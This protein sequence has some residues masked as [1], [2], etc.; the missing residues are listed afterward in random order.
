M[1]WPVAPAREFPREQLASGS[2]RKRVTTILAGS[3]AATVIGWASVSLVDDL[4]L[5]F[6]IAAVI[7]ALLSAWRW[8]WG[9]LAVLL[10]VTVEGLVTNSLY[11]ATVP[12]FFKDML[13]AASYLGFLAAVGLRRQPWPL[14]ATVLWP[15]VVLGVVCAVEAVNPALGD[16]R[17]A[18]V[19]MRVLLFYTPLYILGWAA[20]SAT[21]LQILHRTVRLLLYTSVPI[22]AFGIYEWL[23]GPDA[24]SHLGPGLARSIWIV[25]P[26][27]TAQ[28]IYRPASTFAFV[29]HYGA[30]LLVVSL[31]AFA[32]LHMPWARRERLLLVGV[33]FSAAI[34]V[35]VQAQR[36][37]W[38]LLPIAVAGVY[39][40]S[41]N[42]W[43]ML[44]ALPIVAVG[45]VV[46]VV[47]GGSVL[48]NR[49]PLLTSGFSLYGDRLYAT[50]AGS[51]I[52]ADLF[53]I[54]GL[55]GHGTGSALGASRYVTQGSVP[56]A[57]ESGWFGTFYMFG[58]SGPLVY[59][60]L[61]AAV[62]L[63]AWR[64]TLTIATGQRW[65]GLAIFCFLVLTAVVDGPVA[66]PPT[67]VYVWLFAG[68]L[69][70]LS[71]HAQ[72]QHPQGRTADGR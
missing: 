37:T 26:E 38:V 16:Q 24:V 19:G 60:W 11:P 68:L 31:L 28:P 33:F 5:L 32:A 3:A 70:G 8:R 57:F 21:G 1:S 10:Y 44:R 15:F 69:S 61:Y 50:G 17:V 65:L 49:L 4:E 6:V 55:T 20:T 41:R 71:P 56:T 36:T 64:G 40:L 51:F 30:Y 9:L 46:A 43:G 45:V 58:L 14:P 35:V 66:Y 47:I 67:N 2:G 72:I 53:S 29:G 34:A 7:G 27:A 59:V 54:D 42:V 63:R 13:L 25:G 12:L 23:V 48:G 18:L 39:L 52:E 22:T 62:L